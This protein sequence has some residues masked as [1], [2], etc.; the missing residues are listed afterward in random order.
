[1]CAVEPLDLI[2]S[3]NETDCSYW[4][5]PRNGHESPTA[6]VL[7]GDS[8]EFLVGLSNHAVESLEALELPGEEI[9]HLTSLLLE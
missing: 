4:A 9:W 7:L 2:D 6:F 5:D 8:R 3:S 1:M